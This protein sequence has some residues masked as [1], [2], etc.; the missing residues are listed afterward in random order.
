MAWLL[1]TYEAT[2]R[3]MS[4]SISILS[5][6][7]AAARSA[8][9]GTGSAD[10][11]SATRMMSGCAVALTTAQASHSRS[12]S[13]SPGRIPVNTIGISSGA[14]PES[15]T[16]SRASPA[17][18]DR[19]THVQHEQLAAEAMPPAWSTRCTASGMVMKN[20]G[21]VGMGQGDRPPRFDLPLE[22]RDDA[23]AAAE[24]VA[25]ADDDE[26]ARPSGAQLRARCTRRCAS[27]RPSCSAAS[28]ALSVEISTKPLRTGAGAASTTALRA[29]A[30]C[31]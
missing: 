20:R 7:C 25:E 14:K 22:M 18:P 23:A 21:H 29:R 2:C 26:R 9:I 4:I 12:S 11:G 16:R 13:F 28:T 17:D 19:F 5:P 3:V 10:C 6:A 24:H 15:V 30:Y 31:W 1:G 8:S 27:T